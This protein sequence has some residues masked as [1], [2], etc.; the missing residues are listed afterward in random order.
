[1]SNLKNSLIRITFK[2]KS[3]DFD[4]YIDTV[5]PN[6]IYKWDQL[7]KNLCEGN[8]KFREILNYFKIKSY[9]WES[10]FLTLMQY[11]C[12]ELKMINLRFK[13]IDINKKL[14]GISKVSNIIINLKEKFGLTGDFESLHKIVESVN[15]KI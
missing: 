11:Q 3:V 5:L 10:E 9:D 2:V 1:M 7:S 4:I 15:K 6:T 14:K 8:V 13:Q 12:S